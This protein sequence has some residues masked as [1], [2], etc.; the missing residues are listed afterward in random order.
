MQKFDNRNDKYHNIIYTCR[1]YS[2]KFVTLLI[3][4]I[5]GY[6]IVENKN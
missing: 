3:Y 5:L 6:E 4:K 1:L 2:F